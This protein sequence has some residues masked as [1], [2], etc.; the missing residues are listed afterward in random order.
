MSGNIARMGSNMAFM[1]L[2]GDE[3][4]RMLELLHNGPATITAVGHEIVSVVW[5]RPEK[6]KG[7]ILLPDAL[8]EE[9]VWQGKV[10]LVVEMGPDCYRPDAI[11]TAKTPRCKVGD[12]II[13]NPLA[14][15]KLQVNNAIVRIIHDDQVEAVVNGPQGVL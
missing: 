12:W 10:S 1:T 2:S 9:D 7:N 11:Q 13:T 14:G 6:T 5:I 4:A 3:R 8:R 15:Q